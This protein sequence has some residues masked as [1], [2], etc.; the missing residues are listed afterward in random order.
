MSDE[1]FVRQQ[2]VQIKRLWSTML[3]HRFLIETRDGT[4]ADE[5]FANWMRQDYLFVEAAIPFVA[6]LIPKAPRQHW[7]PLSDVV[8]AL[9]KELKMFEERAATVDVDLRGTPIGFINH[10]YIQYLMATAYR[11]TYAEAYTVYYVAEKAY[12]DSWSVVKAGIARN[13]KWYPFVEYWGGEDFGQYVAYLEKELN[14]M[15]ARADHELRSAM[16]EYFEMTVKYEIAFWE[17]ALTGAE[18]PG[19]ALS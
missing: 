1:S 9:E 14:S 7:N 19:I 6:A 10:A 16:A 5:T 12:Y 3:D 17:M 11:A 18:W 4:I 15:A 13:S 8:G 2:L